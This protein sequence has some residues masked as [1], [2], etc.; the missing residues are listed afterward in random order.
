MLRLHGLSFD[1]VRYSR[2]AGRCREL[3]WEVAAQVLAAGVPVVLDW[4]MY[5]RE[6]RAD[7]VRRA[8]QIGVRCHLHY[9]KVPI[10][11]AVA[12]AAGRR[13]ITS[14]T[15]DAEHIAHLQYIFEA[16]GRDEG[17]TLHEVEGAVPPQGPRQ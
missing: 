10:D 5:S 15:L 12:R 2:L 1:D 13:D 4:N 3:I 16:P 8:E 11:V 7:A 6:R 17:F 9:L 14:H